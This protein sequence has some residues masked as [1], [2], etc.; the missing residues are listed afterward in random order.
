MHLPG[1]DLITDNL[2][3]LLWV[4]Q[5][6]WALKYTRVFNI[7]VDGMAARAAQ[8]TLVY[9]IPVHVSFRLTVDEDPQEWWCST[10][11][12]PSTC[13]AATST[14]LRR[15]LSRCQC[16]LSSE[17]CHVSQHAALAMEHHSRCAPACQVMAKASSMVVS[18][19]AV[20]DQPLVSAL[21]IQ[22]ALAVVPAPP[23]PPPPPPPPTTTP[24]PTPPV[25]PPY[26]LRLTLTTVSLLSTSKTLPHGNS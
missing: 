24:A 7:L 6:Y 3:K 4:L 23:P 18:F 13:R 1:N 21:S 12:T 15:S 5:P 16:P 9:G 19:A 17:L 26:P 2:N 20:L 8:H 10:R 22:T 25:R 14:G 11:T